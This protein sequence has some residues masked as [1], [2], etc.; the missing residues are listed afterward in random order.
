MALSTRK[1]CCIGVAAIFLC[2]AVVL[3]FPVSTFVSPGQHDVL[4]IANITTL[5]HFYGTLSDAPH[6][7]TFHIAAPTDIL[8]SVFVP[9]LPEQRSDISLLV[10][11]E[12]ERGLDL[13]S[14][15]EAARASWM[16]S[17]WWS[18]G[19]TYRKGAV[20]HDTLSAGDYEIEVSTPINQGSYVLVLGTES[21]STLMAYRTEL[22][23][24]FQIKH[25]F[26]KSNVASIES[27]LLFV[28]LLLVIWSLY[29]GWRIYQKR[30]GMVY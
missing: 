26:H 24:L 13:V 23:N 4:P 11:R 1:L 25:F 5:Q 2:L 19:D 16:S 20:W 12:K 22:T 27:P 18:T 28:P 14:R 7:Y 3:R 29:E 8:L 6:L 21:T 15:L 10:L 17:A 30:R 9:D